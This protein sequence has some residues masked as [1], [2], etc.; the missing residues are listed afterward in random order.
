MNDFDYEVRQR[1]ALVPS[2]RR[3]I[4]G[5]KSKKCSLPSDNL[6]S[7]Q[8]KKMSGPCISVQMNAPMSYGEF[9]TLSEDLQR[10][11][12]R[13]LQEK[14]RAKLM[15][16]AD[17]LSVSRYTLLA[18]YKRLGISNKFPPASTEAIKQ[19]RLAW[20]QFVGEPL[21]EDPVPTGSENPASDEP[22]NPASDE[23]ENPG[24][25]TS[26]RMLQKITIQEFSG[27]LERT[28]DL[29]K[30]LNSAN[31]DFPVEINLTITRKESV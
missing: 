9:K 12:I 27:T 17:M 26:C 30:I 7:G 14:Y 21:T 11:Y 18:I 23:P 8:L 19:K 4:N 29:M 10:E 28:Q 16:I 3:R 20:E 13:G 15:W 25:E 5:S 22:E 24:P 31:L 1:K 6:T 2:A